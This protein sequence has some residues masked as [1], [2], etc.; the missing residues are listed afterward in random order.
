MFPS[1]FWSTTN[2]KYYIAGK[3]HHLFYQ[4]RVKKMVYSDIPT[5]VFSR[6]TNASSSTSSDYCYAIFG[7]ESMCSIAKNHCDMRQHRKA[8]T[9]SNTAASGLYL[10]CKDDSN[11][12]HYIDRRQMIKK[13][14]AYQEY[15]QMGYLPHIYL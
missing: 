13:L 15:F 4:V 2:D 9:S 7:Y 5:H 14:C 8:M 10:R 6:L 12:L 1:M 11:F 3:F